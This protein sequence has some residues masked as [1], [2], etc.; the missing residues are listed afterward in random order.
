MKVEPSLELSVLNDRPPASTDRVH[1]GFSFPG[2]CQSFCLLVRL[3][4]IIDFPMDGAKLKFSLVILSEGDIAWHH[5]VNVVLIPLFH[6]NNPPCSKV[7]IAHWVLLPLR[8]HT[9][10]AYGF[11]A[12]RRNVANALANWVLFC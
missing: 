6:L 4:T 7:W 11:A 5:E 2:K 8:L 1:F 12:V 3:N 10:H 9:P